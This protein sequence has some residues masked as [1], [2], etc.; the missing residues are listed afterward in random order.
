MARVLVHVCHDV[1]LESINITYV[2]DI[3]IRIKNVKPSFES[4]DHH[5]LTLSVSCVVIAE[6][7]VLLKN[8][9]PVADTELPPFSF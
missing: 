2:C 8:N 9:L 5:I 7:C 3:C 1:S 4:T 6:C